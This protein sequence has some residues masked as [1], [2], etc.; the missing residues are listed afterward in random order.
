MLAIPRTLRSMI[1][2]FLASSSSLWGSS[3]LGSVSTFS[4]EASELEVASAVTEYNLEII[5]CLDED[6][7]DEERW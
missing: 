7:R 6:V 2:L 3:F 1:S 4:A 5:L